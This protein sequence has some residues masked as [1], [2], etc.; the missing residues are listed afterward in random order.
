MATV[1]IMVRHGQAV[2][3][4][5]DILTGVGDKGKFPL[6]AKG[7]EQIR[8]AAKQLKKIKVDKIYS[9]EVLRAKQSAL[10][11][12]KALG[13]KPVF[14][15]GI[16]EREMGNAAGKPRDDGYWRWELP[17]R[18]LATV[19]PWERFMRRVRKFV[20]S[21]P[22]KNGV[23][24]LVGHDST[25]KAMIISLLGLD[26]A[27]GFGVRVPNASMSILKVSKGGYEIIAIGA[28][29]LDDKMMARIRGTS[30]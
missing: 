16:S 19:E 24:V 18:V 30:N 15:A 21:L 1:I 9:S 7:R 14:F 3:N 13:K 8:F 28:P 10:I 27:S 4:V 20:D 22:K 6:T 11:I 25:I 2:S 5:K 12:G 26:D 29:V 17:K 23:I